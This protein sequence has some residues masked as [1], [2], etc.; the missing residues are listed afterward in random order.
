METKEGRG[1]D[2]QT[3]DDEKGKKNWPSLWVD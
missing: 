2:E 1:D 3:R